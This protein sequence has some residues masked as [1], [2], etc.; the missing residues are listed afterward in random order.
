MSPANAGQHCHPAGRYCQQFAP[1]TGGFGIG[2]IN[3]CSI[4]RNLPRA[5][6]GNGDEAAPVRI[7]LQQEVL[8]FLDDHGV[9]FQRFL[10]RDNGQWFGYCPKVCLGDK[11]SGLFIP[12]YF[13]EFVGEVHKVMAIEKLRQT[14]ERVLHSFGNV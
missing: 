4:Q 8:A 6:S 10:L 2:H 12:G 9:S 11:I 1:A 14:G 7:N 13:R 3:A 5:Q